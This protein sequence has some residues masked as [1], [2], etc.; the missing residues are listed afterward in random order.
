MEQLKLWKKFLP[1]L[2]PIFIFIIVDEIWGTIPGVIAAV[3][4][5]VAELVWVWF[6][7]HKFDKFVLFD[8]ILLVVLGGVSVVLNNDIFFKLKPGLI[9]VI[10][11]V[12][13]GI[14][15]FSSFNITGMMAQRYLKGISVTDEHNALMRRI[16]RVI[17]WIFLVHTALVFYS[18]FFMSKEAWAFISGGLF[19][20]I[21]AVMAVGMFVNA[22]IKRRKMEDEEWVPL[23]ND[24]GAIIGKA[25]RL[26]VHRG[27]KMLHPVVH[28]HI[29]NTKKQILLQKRPLNKEMQPGKWDTAVGGH[30]VWGESIETALKREA[31]EETGLTQFQAKL[32][33]VYRWETD[34]E[35]EQVY[36]FIT[37]VYNFVSNPQLKD[38]IDELRFW[39]KAEIR[40]NLGKSIFTSNFEHEFDLMTTGG[41]I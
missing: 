41:I 33:Y 29:I 28:L 15:A 27:E 10:L 2:I 1:G 25:P 8:T 24:E 18:A 13:I 39:S 14:S 17:F 5:G 35:A 6:K 26:A 23:V 38:E 37:Y 30:I 34:V 11:L 21:F 19:Y 7:E 9:E 36:C 32:L 31:E 4:V 16:L 3:L 40:K 12:I 20:I 22:K